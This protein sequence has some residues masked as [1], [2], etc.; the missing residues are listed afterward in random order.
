L[1]DETF[2]EDLLDPFDRIIL[3]A[4]ATV[5]DIYGDAI[6]RLLSAPH[7][8]LETIVIRASEKQKDLFAVTEVL[9]SFENLGVRRREDL[10][11]AAGGGI[12][13][14]IVAFASN[15]YRRGVPC[16]RLPTTLVAQID[17]GIGVKNAVNFRHKKSR[18]GTFAAPYAVVVDP[19][20]LSTL[21]DRQI[22]NGLSEALKIA[23][24]V[25][26]P[27]FELIEEYAFQFVRTKLQ[28]SQGRDLIQASIRAMLLELSPNLYE[29]TLDRFPDYGHT[30]SPIFE[31]EL[32]DLEHGEAVA[33]DMAVATSLA[34]V[35]GT[36]DI[37]D[38]ERILD[39]QHGLGLPIVREG[40]T[41]EMLLRGLHEARKHRG[42]QLRMP[43]LSGIGK[44]IF[45]DAIS[46]SDLQEA[47]AY[48]QAWRSDRETEEARQ[49]A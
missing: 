14:D 9:A 8:Q 3:V 1:R 32:S 37:E 2:P 10:I 6:R 40:L 47:L 28:C 39:T 13:L 34:T 22:R 30:F 45:I 42:G 44:G 29:R 23:L 38:A 31:F 4:D 19:C 33:L 27:L 36:L 49:T 35:L 7:R 17:A 25:D 11:V 20:F 18:L 26:R 24:V 16:L 21:S 12:T 46:E 15:L 41:I 5:N 43:I 48:V